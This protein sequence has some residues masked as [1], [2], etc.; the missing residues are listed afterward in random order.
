VQVLIRQPAVSSR[1]ELDGLALVMRRS[2]AMPR[3]LAPFIYTIF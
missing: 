1:A 2:D 3:E